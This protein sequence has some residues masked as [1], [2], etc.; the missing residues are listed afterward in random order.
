MN[1]TDDG[2]EPVGEAPEVPSRRGNGHASM[3][4]REVFRANIKTVILM[5][6]RHDPGIYAADRFGSTDDI[7]QCPFPCGFRG[8]LSEWEQHLADKLADA[9]AGA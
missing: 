6:D 9:L 7:Y 3:L 2:L 4:T 8:T 1:A 5:F